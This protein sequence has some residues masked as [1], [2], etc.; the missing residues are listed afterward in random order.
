MSKRTGALRII[1]AN[2]SRV[3]EP[4]GVARRLLELVTDETVLGRGEDYPI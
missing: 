4:I 1:R 3:T 2:S